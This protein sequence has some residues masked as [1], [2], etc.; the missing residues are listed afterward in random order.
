MK[1]WVIGYDGKKQQEIAK[2]TSWKETSVTNMKG[3]PVY[4]YQEIPCGKCIECRMSYA[5]MWA[6]RCMLEAREWEN[7]EMLTLTYDEQHIPKTQGIDVKTGELKEVQTLKKK[8]VQ[9]FLKRL[10]KAFKG[11]IRYFM[12]GEYGTKN[13]RPHYHLIVYNLKV[14][15]KRK[16]GINEKGHETFTSP[17]IEKIW[18]K[19]RIDLQP[20][21]YESCEYVARYVLKKQKGTDAKETY[22]DRGQTPEYTC[23][24]RKPGIAYKYFEKKKEEIYET[25]K[26][27]ISKKKTLTAVTPPRYF[28]KLLEKED[29]DKMQAIKL[30]RQEMAEYKQREQRLTTPLSRE[31]T[32]LKHQEILQNRTTKYDRKY[33]RGA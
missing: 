26:I 18:G 3:R 11:P 24:S 25:Q 12:C 9:D 8:D 30:K 4:K 15:D 31:E 1:R 5:K 14:E 10:R 27:W 22:Q 29:F 16:Q 2:I 7:N 28:D 20:V 32:L 6:T 21:T 13:G 17:K 23:M 19:G 33:E